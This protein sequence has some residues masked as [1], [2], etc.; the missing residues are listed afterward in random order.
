MSRWLT[1]F[2]AFLLVAFTAAAQQSG[3]ETTAFEGIRS[4]NTGS[5]SSHSMPRSETG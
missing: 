2:Q 4:H 1:L 5:A 3:L